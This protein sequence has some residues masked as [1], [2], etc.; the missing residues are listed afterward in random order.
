MVECCEGIVALLGIVELQ[1]LLEGDHNLHLVGHN[2]SVHAFVN[3][4]RGREW[5]L[6]IASY[7]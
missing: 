3:T 4:L 1:L 5:S 7:S 6:P 2:P